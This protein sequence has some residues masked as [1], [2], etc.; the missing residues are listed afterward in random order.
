MPKK[1]IFPVV[2]TGNLTEDG[3]VAYMR[4]DRRRDRTWVTVLSE[5]EIIESTALLAERLN[6]AREQEQWICDP[7]AMSVRETGN[8]IEPCS[9][10]EQIR[11][12]GP[13]TRIRRPDPHQTAGPGH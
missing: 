3:S 8:E 2:L 11:S 7:Y 13:T 1:T 10:R 4:R 9:T 6:E 12:Q 5:A